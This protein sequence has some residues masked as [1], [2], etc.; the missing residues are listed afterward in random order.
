VE[1]AVGGGMWVD[2]ALHKIQYIGVAGGMD[3]GVCPHHLT[4]ARYD[5]MFGAKYAHVNLSLDISPH[6]VYEK[7]FFARRREET[8]GGRL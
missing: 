4:S 6:W 7:H 2:M 3:V 1:K 8:Y 5:V